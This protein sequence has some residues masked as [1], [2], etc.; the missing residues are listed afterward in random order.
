MLGLAVKFILNIWDKDTV[1]IKNEDNTNVFYYKK[2]TTYYF[3]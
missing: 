1:S 3:I 2:Y